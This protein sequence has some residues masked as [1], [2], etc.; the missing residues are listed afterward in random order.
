[1]GIRHAVDGGVVL[2]PELEKKREEGRNEW[3][4]FWVNRV[5]GREI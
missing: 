5:E 4:D 1:M 3:I 2:S